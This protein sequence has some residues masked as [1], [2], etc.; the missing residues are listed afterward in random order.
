[1][2]GTGQVCDNCHWRVTVGH[3]EAM[4]LVGNSVPV[5]ISG[6]GFGTTPSITLSGGIT[7]SNITASDTQISATLN[8]P[9]TAPGGDQTLTV[10]NQGFS[11]QGDT[12]FVQ[13]P[14][15]LQ[16]LSQRVSTKNPTANGCPA[17]DTPPEGPYGM[18]LALRYQV[19]D[20]QATAIVATMPLREDLLNLVVDGQ[21]QGSATNL[22]V[23]PSGS[24]DPDGTFV[25]DPVG[26]CATGPFTSATFTQRLYIPLSTQVSPT[27]KTNNYSQT[28]KQGCGSSTNGG[29]ISVSVP[30]N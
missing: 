19:L 13:V 4:G 3:P 16:A 25:D 2:S 30:C 20:Q 18:K 10:T 22:F 5:T 26:A 1:M 29:D 28:G 15:S 6:K 23:T 21:G 7:A 8:I 24:T 12:F 27:V 9:V 11:T 14:T 17:V